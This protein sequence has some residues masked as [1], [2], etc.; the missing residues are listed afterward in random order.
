MLKHRRRMGVEQKHKE[1]LMV[2]EVQEIQCIPSQQNFF[3]K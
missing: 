3:A 1:A 2:I